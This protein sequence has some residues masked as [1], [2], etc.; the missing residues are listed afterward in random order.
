M[1]AHF[2]PTVLPTAKMVIQ[3]MDAKKE[4]LRIENCCEETPQLK[5][6]RK[7]LIEQISF[8]EKELKK[9]GDFS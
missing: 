6:Y 5:R 4:L 3:L 2:I 7:R 8:L 9:L 1:D